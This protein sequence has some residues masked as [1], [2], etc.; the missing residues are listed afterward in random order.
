LLRITNRAGKLFCPKINLTC[1][2][3]LNYQSL[4]TGI[5]S[6]HFFN[7]FLRSKPVFSLS[8]HAFLGETI[9]TLAVCNCAVEFLIMLDALVGFRLPVTASATITAWV[10]DWIISIQGRVVNHEQGR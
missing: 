4:R 6:R 2:L 5:F 7:Y 3:A 8:A 9:P 1:A 10:A